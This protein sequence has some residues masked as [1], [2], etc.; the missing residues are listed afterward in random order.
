M[1]GAVTIER[2]LKDENLLGAALGPIGSW[3]TW[4]AVLKAAFGEALTPEEVEVFAVV[5]GGRVPPSRRC[6]ELWC[7]PIGRRSGKSRTAAA[8]S[9]FI[10][11]LVDHSRRLAPGELGVVAIIAASREQARTVHGY[12]RGF[13]EASELLRGEIE[14]IGAEEIRLRGNIAIC[15]VTNSYRVARGSTLLCVV[16]DEISFWR[17]EESATPDLETYRACLPSLVASG[18]MWVGIS[19]G[20]RRAGLLH[21]KYRAHFGVA[22]DDVLCVSGPTEVFNPLID[23]EVIRKASE[24]DPES[25]AAQWLGR[26]RT[27]IVGFLDDALIEQA[28]DRGRPLELPPRAGVYYRAYVD[29][30]GGAVGGDAYTIA[31]AHRE[32]GC[33]VLD[34]VRGRAGPFDPEELTKEYAA[35]CKQYRCSGVVGDKYGAEWVASAWRKCGVVYTAAALT[36]SE[37]YCEALP[38]WT[39][40][41]VRIPNHLALQRELRLL[42]RRPTRLGRDQVTH[43]RGVHDD[44]ANVCFGAL[45]GLASHLGAYADLLGA[46]TRW[47]DEPAA[48]QS[49]LQQQAEQRHRALM[50]RYGQPVSLNPIPREHVEA[51]KA[52]DLLPEHVREGLARAKADALRRRGE[53]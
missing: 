3:R 12:V 48:E 36:A 11:V 7:G 52:V 4:V 30:S 45:Y 37:T 16:G 51:A 39:R 21:A 32:D 9:A 41:A 49:Y 13:L 22:S 23:R 25:A 40:A 15:V 10:A 26:F 24:E 47:D 35:L 2:A 34:V 44:H 20:Y 28:V 5:A 1:R 33:Y 42:E 53:T 17:S 29:A 31:I 8:V 18:G 46:A 19:T 43:P 6:R 27:D 50:E 38:L 14:S